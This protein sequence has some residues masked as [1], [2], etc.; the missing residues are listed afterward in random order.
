MTEHIDEVQIELFVLNSPSVGD[1]RGV[2]SAHLDS[3]IE[4]KE[5]Y[6]SI[7]GFYRDVQNDLDGEN[8]LPAI[9][10]R[11]LPV[12]QPGGRLPDRASVQQVE[13]AVPFR[14]ARWVMKHPYVAGSSFVGVLALMVAMFL[15]LPLKT[16]D[17]NS[18]SAEVRG[19]M[20]VF[21]NTRGEQIDQFS[22]GEKSASQLKVSRVVFFDL[23]HDG[24]NE[25]FWGQRSI[26][27]TR[28]NLQLV[29]WSSKD[30]EVVW[31]SDLTPRLRFPN[32]PEITSDELAVE[33]IDIGDY[34]NDGKV[35]AYIRLIHPY[36]P[37]LLMKVDAMSGKEIGTYLHVGTLG[38]PLF[39]DLD[40]D[41]VSE[42]IMAGVNQAYRAACVVVLDSRFIDGRSPTN[43]EY[44]ID[45]WHSAS[46]RAYI[47]IP[48]TI[49]GAA[50]EDE[51]K[52][53]LA[54]GPEL[55]TSDPSFK[56]NV[57]ELTNPSLKHTAT[58]FIR[59]GPDLAVEDIGTGDDYDIL[60]EQLLKEHRIRQKPNRTYFDEF[61]KTLLYWDGETW[62]NQFSLNKRY[63]E[64]LAKLKQPS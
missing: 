17:T 25:A 44:A 51:V 12:R 7:S 16:R 30:H 34:D 39:L 22:L 20:M 23:N 31:S 40:K 29:C 21:L 2:I 64:A 36:F 62:Q 58:L 8:R 10:R 48:K 28:T 26:S 63:L 50:F 11:D 27:V 61:K 4:C 24:V 60:A 46:E 41:G 45:D 54:G 32:K 49:V 13:M 15:V 35:E 56:V 57:E 18:V 14:A 47:R 53:N 33:S 55:I 1:K 19:D 38:K 6:E 5:L 52:Y 43:D 37:C 59:F 9:S 42:I 3:C